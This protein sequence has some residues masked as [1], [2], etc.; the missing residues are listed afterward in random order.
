MARRKLTMFGLAWPLLVE[1]MLRFFMGDVNVFMLSRV[2]DNAVAS[3]GSSNQIVNLFLAFYMIIYM[4]SSIIISQYL[5][6]GDEKTA[7][8]ISS[9]AI[10]LNLL[11]GLIVS[12]IIIIFAPIILTA[13]KIPETL[14]PDSIIYLRIVGGASFLQAGI[15]TMSQ[16]ARN[17]GTTKYPMY[18]A[19]IM[20]ALNILSSY[21][22]VFRPFGIPEFGVAGVAVGNILSACVGLALLTLVLHRRH[23][24]KIKMS[25][26]LPFPKSE[27]KKIFGIGVPC[28]MESIAYM[29]MSTTMVSVIAL[30][31]SAA[32]SARIYTQSISTYTTIYAN[33]IALATQILVG[34]QVGAGKTDEA[35]KTVFKCLKYTSL[36]C[37]VMGAVAVIFRHSIVKI[38]TNDS[39]IIAMV[40]TAIIINA[41]MTVAKATNNTF[42]NSLKGV[43]DAKFTMILSVASMW[44]VAIPLSYLFSITLNLGFAGIW[45]ALFCDEWLRS[46]IFFFRWRSKKWQNKIIIKSPTPQVDT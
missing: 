44:G 35:S 1:N 25:S 33:A 30:L 45:L 31:G 40:S 8:K 5:G 9:V 39:E 17:Y 43:G 7:H 29:I 15:T 6:A 23:N 20:S 16:I 21:I 3:V 24:I 13:M 32:L 28:A 38:F 18:I 2:S 4:G 46:I 41:L 10:T 12:L 19:L 27:I 34:Q 14:L 37:V 36:I 22:V 26:M 11:F 42:A